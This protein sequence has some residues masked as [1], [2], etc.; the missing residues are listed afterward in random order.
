VWAAESMLLSDYLSSSHSFVC[1]H[2]LCA[3]YL[4]ESS[5]VWSYIVLVL[6]KM[7]ILPSNLHVLHNSHQNPCDI[8]HRDQKIYTTVHLESQ[9]TMNSQGNTQ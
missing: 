1:F 6:L 7:A 9:E 5:V 3:E 4:V 8:H 2:F